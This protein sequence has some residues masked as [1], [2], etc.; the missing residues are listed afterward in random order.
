MRIMEQREKELDPWYRYRVAEVT[1]DLPN[2]SGI[3][4]EVGVF[5]SFLCV[6]VCIYI[7]IC[8]PLGIDTASP[9]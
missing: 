1:V 2:C 8:L 9:R 7:Y 6:C 4:E 3:F 5:V